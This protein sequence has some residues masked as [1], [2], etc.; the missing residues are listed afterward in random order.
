MFLR[1]AETEL[2]SPES[3]A[4]AIQL[5]AR[6]LILIIQEAQPL[7]IQPATDIMKRTVKRTDGNKPSSRPSPFKKGE[8]EKEIKVPFLFKRERDL[9]NGLKGG[10]D[11]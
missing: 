8:G 4:I 5:N 1:Y 3:C 11:A 9:G 6:H 2:Q 7:V 10:V